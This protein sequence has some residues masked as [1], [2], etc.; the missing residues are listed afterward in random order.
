MNYSSIRDIDALLESRGLAPSR[1][2]GQNFLINPGA[3]DTLIDAC[4]TGA[5]SVVWEIGPGI[6]TLSVRLQQIATSLTLFEIDE[7]FVRLLEERFEAFPSVHIV[8]GD[9]SVTFPG[10]IGDSRLP[11]LIVGNLPYNAAAHIVLRLFAAGV[12]SRMVITVQREVA[13]R[14]AAPVGSPAYSS[15]SILCQSA[16]DVRILGTLRPGSFHPRPRVDSAMVMLEPRVLQYGCDRGFMLEFCRCLFAARRKTVA[17]NLRSCRILDPLS[18]EERLALLRSEGG[19][20]GERSER[21]SPDF[22][23]RLAE[24]FSRAILSRRNHLRKHEPE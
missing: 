20:P 1:R 18:Q 12:E 9:F 16:W 19:D 4:G 2:F 6:G 11:D 23:V 14:M 24:S 22:V 5:C 7:G 3:E 15:F 8:A 21:F 10:E 17:N 13:E